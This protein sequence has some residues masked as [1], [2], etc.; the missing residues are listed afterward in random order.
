MGVRRRRRARTAVAD[1]EL[2]ARTTASVS[3]PA[4]DGRFV[5][6]EEDVVETAFFALGCPFF[7][8]LALGWCS[9]A[10]PAIAFLTG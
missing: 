10:L 3:C 7:R 9:P 5:D 6:A 8:F 2:V 1:L 4:S